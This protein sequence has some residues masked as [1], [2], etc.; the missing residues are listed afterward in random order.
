MRVPNTKQPGEAV[1]G[2]F[3]SQHNEQPEYVA[4]ST[5]PT[6]ATEGETGTPEEAA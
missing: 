3:E 5:L 4:L 1:L 2:A 6:N